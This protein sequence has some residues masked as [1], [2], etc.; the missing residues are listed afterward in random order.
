LA[1][2]GEWDV[3]GR[4]LV[5]LADDLLDLLSYG[6]KADPERL[7][8]LR[9]DAFTLA[10]EAEQ[11]VL[12]ADVVVIKHPGFFFRQD[13]NPPRPLVERLEHA[14]RSLP[15]GSRHSFADMN[16]IHLVTATAEL[17]HRSVAMPCGLGQTRQYGS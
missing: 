5:A 10:D 1:R 3:P 4:R 17:R 14:Q 7:Q 15:S 12:G 6:V 13:N 2:L 8:Y 9:G 16:T 11:D